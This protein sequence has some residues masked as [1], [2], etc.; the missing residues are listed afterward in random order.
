MSNTEKYLI[1]SASDQEIHEAI[2]KFKEMFPQNQE[3]QA[4]SNQEILEEVLKQRDTPQGFSFPMENVDVLTE[5]GTSPRCAEAIALVVIYC[6][7]LGLS[8]CGCDVDNDV[9]A[10]AAVEGVAKMIASNQKEWDKYLDHLINAQSARAKAD[11]IWDII[12]FAWDK[13]IFTYIF[14]KIKEHMSLLDWIKMGVVA[15]LELIAAL[16]SDGLAIIVKIAAMVPQMINIVE[17]AKKA[18]TICEF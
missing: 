2:V 9:I 3:L 16:V 6:V 5:L 1:L 13:N 10:R 14:D 7:A 11:A 18:Y 4:I 17:A 15:M 8:A 12:K